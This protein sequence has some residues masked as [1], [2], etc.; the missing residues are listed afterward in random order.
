LPLGAGSLTVYRMPVWMIESFGSRDLN[1]LFW[2]IT[3]LP[4]PFWLA[5]LGA[6][7]ARLT[8]RLANPWIV[9]GLFGLL[10]LAL[11]YKLA[12]LGIHAPEGV[13]YREAKSVLHHPLVFLTLWN[14]AQ[15]MNLFA[16]MVIYNEGGRSTR[17]ALLL[18]WLLGPVGVLTY[19]LQQMLTRK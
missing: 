14:T 3:L 8:A 15:A 1:H 11:L 18:T 2:L 13:A 19:G 16:G 7:R 17:L 4:V 12:E 9:P 5:M 6:P 10:T